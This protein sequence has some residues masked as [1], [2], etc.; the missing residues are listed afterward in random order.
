MI[1]L[2]TDYAAVEKASS[3]NLRED[4]IYPSIC[5]DGIC[6][7]IPVILRKHEKEFLISRSVEK[8]CIEQKGAQ[9]MELAWYNPYFMFDD[10]QKAKN[11]E[12]DLPS[13]LRKLAG[14]EK[15]RCHGDLPCGLYSALKKQLNLQR[16]AP[17][18]AP[19]LFLYRVPKEKAL[20]ASQALP[21][22]WKELAEKASAMLDGEVQQKVRPYL[23]DPRRTASGNLDRL[24]EEAG[25][26]IVVADTPVD[27]QDLAGLPFRRIPQGL[28]ALYRRGDPEI[29]V[30][31]REKIEGPQ[32]IPAGTLKFREP[33]LNHLYREGA[34]GIGS[35][36]PISM[37]ERLHP[38]WE[39]LKIAT[40][41]FR[42]WRERYAW[43]DLPYYIVGAQA[44]RRAV[45]GSLDFAQKKLRA[46]EGLREIEIFRRHWTLLD[47]FRK[48]H[49]L[50]QSF[51][52]YFANLHATSRTLYPSVPV[53]VPV[54]PRTHCI[55]FDTGILVFSA[56]GFLKA[57]SD[58]GRNMELKDPGKGLYGILG[59]T[60]AEVI[61][62]SLKPGRAGR[63][64]YRQIIDE[65]AKHEGDLKKKGLMHEYTS[66][67]SVYKR[68][69]GHLLGR[70][71][72]T[73]LSLNENQEGV[74]EEG[75][76]G[77]IELPWLFGEYAL[78]YEDMFFITASGGVNIS[79]E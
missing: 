24:M 41:V 25:V 28:L 74:L 30:V 61:I 77:A 48:D 37:A 50:A 2:I 44:T 69:V 9:G 23:E 79:R 51:N 52:Y 71:E 75:M 38:D 35:N 53:D 65:L 18:E 46:G 17:Q 59:R 58:I 67:K 64:V 72:P 15:I 20:A 60:I 6:T 45:E 68:D 4:L 66:L 47:E 42:R 49:G 76:V 55:R 36:L 78:G 39:N 56:G 13:A 10:T 43:E 5:L 14:D 40:P 1:E 8:T 34:V 16:A 32:F 73:S 3:L 21:A 63:E 70:E 12:K 54:D 22:E 31:A 27:I 7:T 29:N 57:A 26:D 62:P 19:E 33:I 11:V